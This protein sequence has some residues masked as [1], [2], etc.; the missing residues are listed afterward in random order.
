MREVGV[1]DSKRLSKSRREHLEPLIKAA[2]VEWKLTFVLPEE[3]DALRKGVS[4][5]AIEIEKTAQLLISLNVRP[6]RIIVDAA[7]TIAKNYGRKII[8]NL[9][10]LDPHYTAPPILSEHKADDNYIEVSAASVLAKVA[11]DRAID[12][13]HTTHGNFGSGYPSDPLTQE[14]ISR[15]HA[16]GQR[17]EYVRHSWNTKDVK[18]Q[19]K[20]GDW[21]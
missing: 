4:L 12:L 18:N 8:L 19:T 6:D 20:L 21:G 16:L 14:F 5:N 3:I 7:D 2:A 9:Q 1:K 13:L 15:L 17:P 11:R 10:R